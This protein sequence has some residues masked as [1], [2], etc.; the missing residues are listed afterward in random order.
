MPVRDPED[1]NKGSHW[2]MVL[3]DM[4]TC[5]R[6]SQRWLR[7]QEPCGT[8]FF[9]ALLHVCLQGQDVSSVPSLG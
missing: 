6:S 7:S 4:S 5:S 2:K 9:N 8:V 3:K 1:G